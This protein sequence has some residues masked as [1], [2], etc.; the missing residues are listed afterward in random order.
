[1]MILTPEPTT[2]EALRATRAVGRTVPSLIDLSGEDLGLPTPAHV[3]AAAK[4]ALDEGATHYTTRPGLDP[5]RR[6]V[7]EKLRRDSGVIVDAQREVLITCGTQEALFVTLHVLLAH[8]DEVLVPQPARPAYAAITR[9]AGGIVRAIPA[10]PARGF[11]LD[12]DDVARRLTRRSRVLIL[13]DPAV[14]AGTVADASI[15]QRLADLA[16]THNLVVVSDEAYEPFVYDGARHH[17]F[18]ALPGMA[19]R[20]ITINGFSTAYAMAGWRVGYVAGPAQLMKP[21]QQLKQALSICSPAVS[22][23]AA[24]AALT[25]PPT[26]VEEAYQAVSERRAATLDAL[27]K[28]GVP[29]IRPAGGYYILVDGRA[30]GLTGVALSRWVARR[31]GVRLAPGSAFGPVTAR[32][33]RLSLTQSPDR[34]ANAAGRLGD[35]LGVGN[36]AGMGGR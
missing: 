12:P 18:A 8:G 4:R 5:L 10:D 23:Y 17:S 1:M 27:Q 2:S 14:P 36:R 16:A 6:A 19:E 25:G 13:S 32:W 22:Q 33:L 3:T 31:A 9:Q 11:A 26:P 20:T 21:I 28:T 34:L 24:L 7:A 15:L 29:H 35:A 30:V